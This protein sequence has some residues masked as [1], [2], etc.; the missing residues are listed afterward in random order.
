MRHKHFRRKIIQQRIEEL[1]DKCGTVTFTGRT[2]PVYL[3]WLIFFLL[4]VWDTYEEVPPLDDDDTGL[5][6]RSSSC[7]RSPVCK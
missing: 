2:A 3:V 6:R 4:S 1:I 7:L 5:F